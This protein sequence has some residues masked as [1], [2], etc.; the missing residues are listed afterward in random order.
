[1]P[2]VP[3]HSVPKSSCLK[4][5]KSRRSYIDTSIVEEGGGP[6]KRPDSSNLLD[7]NNIFGSL[8]NIFT[9]STSVPLAERGVPEGQEDITVYSSSQV[10]LWFH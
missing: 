9:F 1:M 6:R 3:T 4:K 5:T 7:S 8:K 2:K 10:R